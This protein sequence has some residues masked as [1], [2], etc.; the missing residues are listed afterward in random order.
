MRTD[1]STAHGQVQ[2][3]S[4]SHSD[5]IIRA[6]TKLKER[7]VENQALLLERICQLQTQCDRLSQEKEDSAVENKRLVKAMQ[8]ME[9]QHR[10][11][12][13]T[14]KSRTSELNEKLNGI[15]SFVTVCVFV[16]ST[17]MCKAFG[18]NVFCH[19]NKQHFI[20]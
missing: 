13:E 8:E 20:V 2:L 6:N 18:M 9:S 3:L 1:I 16:T 10:H 5:I 7:L 11:S 17:P 15:F 19:C 4:K 12:E 14:S